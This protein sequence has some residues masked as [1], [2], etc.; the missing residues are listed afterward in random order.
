MM[1][2]NYA[3]QVITAATGS[4]PNR[5][6]FRGAVAVV[7]ANDRPVLEL[8]AGTAW[9]EPEP[10]AASTATSGPPSA[11]PASQA[12]VGP[13]RL[14]YIFDLASLTKVMATAPSVLLLV[15]H[16]LLALDDPVQLFFPQ[17]AGTPLGL[18]TVRQLLLHTSGLPQQA[19]LFASAYRMPCPGPADANGGCRDGLVGGAVSVISKMRL[20]TPPGTNVNYSCAGYIV[21]GAIV[22]AVA[23]CS[24]HDFATENIFE[25]LGM[26]D[27]GFFPLDRPLPATACG[28]VVPTES[29]STNPRASAYAAAFTQR[30]L[31][32]DEWSA[33]HIAAPGSSIADTAC[34]VV[35]D[36]ESG[37]L[38]GVAGNTGLFS[39]AR[40]IAAFGRMWL[41]EGAGP[42]ERQVLSGAAVAAAKRCYT[43]QCS[44]GDM[45]GLGW[46]LPSADK[47]LGDWAF[48][49]SFGHA[50]FTGTGLWITPSLS[51]VTVLL[52]NRLQLSRDCNR[53]PRLRK[54][55]NN[56]VFAEVTAT[57]I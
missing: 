42:D 16:G 19:D 21:L 53:M 3:S 44:G 48:P 10:A 46:Q 11:A 17:A 6:A 57:S 4:D 7:I 41:H 12:A 39:T 1:V 29:R 56:A 24:L 15:D 23:G 38:G 25:P 33:R 43:S 35:Y 9:P 55:F 49:D 45:R 52:T 51:L 18:V 40:D 5:H 30:G 14:D 47:S 22:E 28:R 36:D 31:W 8:A 37:W 54:L 32:L 2:L 13:M 26:A 34:G 50:G 27:T 20:L